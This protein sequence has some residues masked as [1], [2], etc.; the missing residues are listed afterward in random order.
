MKFTDKKIF[1]TALSAI[2]LSNFSCGKIF[3]AE[4]IFVIDENYKLTKTF[5]TDWQSPEGKI[6]FFGGGGENFSENIFNRQIAIH[7]GNFEKVFG[8]FSSRG[9]VLNNNIHIYGGNFKDVFGGVSDTGSVV[10]NNIHIHGGIFKGGIVGGMV[11]NPQ[12]FSE[13]SNNVINI[14]GMPD[15]QDATLTGGIFGDESKSSGNFL[16]INTVGLTVGKINSDSFEKIIFNLPSTVKNGETILSV[17]G[18]NISADKI[19][20]AIDGNSELQTGD[21]INLVI[22]DLKT[23]EDLESS[24]DID[25]NFTK[26]ESTTS[27]KTFMTRGATLD[28]EV[29][30]NQNSDGS[31]TATVGDLIGPTSNPL[32]QSGD[33]DF[34]KAI[35]PELDPFTEMMTDAELYKENFAGGEKIFSAEKFLGLDDYKFFFNSGNKSVTTKSSGGNVKSSRGSYSLGFARSFNTEFG[36]IYVAPVFESAAGTY[37]ATLS[38]NMFGSGNIKYAAGGIIARVIR[39]N[40]FY[41]EGS[42]RTGRTENNFASNDFLIGGLPTHV[43]YSMEAPIFT[44]HLRIGDAIKIDKDNIFDFY[45]IYFATHQKGK[46]AVLS[47]GENVNFSSATAQTFRFGCRLT[48]RTSK[49]S[50]IYTGLAWQYEKNSDSI[51]TATNYSKTAEGATGSSG[52]IELGWKIKSSKLST[53]NLDLKAVNYFGRQKGF[54]I[55]MTAEKNF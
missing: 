35:I 10:G 47:T 12:K 28:Y 19:S 55:A 30:L 31:I 27:A 37:T 33:T 50:K 2:F 22:N 29:N 46:N 51:A 13:V 48:T 7:G 24:S 9:N 21:K 4:D 52:M 16:N 43:T 20:F 54:N 44:G 26:T 1:F 18:G 41:C 36:K 6:I 14:Y 5:S 23:S 38:N 49:I 40:G 45:G 3:A 25:S 32:P 15:L 34:I 8:G 39:E 17:A 53:W 42:F 11:K